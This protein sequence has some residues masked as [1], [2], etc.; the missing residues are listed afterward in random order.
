ML[1]S[2]PTPFYIFSHPPPSNEKGET[3]SPSY[4]TP[5]KKFIEV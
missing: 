2:Y 3:K 4:D 5:N 1:P